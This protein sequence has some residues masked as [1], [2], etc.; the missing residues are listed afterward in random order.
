MR[1]YVNEDKVIVKDKYLLC[2]ICSDIVIHP[3]KCQECEYLYCQACIQH[4]LKID[5]H[6]PNCRKSFIPTPKLGRYE[7]NRLDDLKFKCFRCADIFTYEY[8]EKH[9]KK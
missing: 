6:C 2:T 8:A 5:E 1:D 7:R 9:A 3:S 4:Q